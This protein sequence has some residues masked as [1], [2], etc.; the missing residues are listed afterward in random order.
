MKYQD[1]QKRKLR[2]GLSQDCDNCS[3]VGHA[4]VPSVDA[5]MV[6]G[7]LSVVDGHGDVCDE[8]RA[9]LYT[10]RVH[11]KSAVVDHVYVQSV[12]IW[13]NHYATIW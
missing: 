4:Y 10:M 3:E 9:E 11:Q 7:R 5:T 12:E 8:T 1:I 6:V 13:L 2:L